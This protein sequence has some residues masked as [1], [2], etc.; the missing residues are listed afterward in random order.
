[1]AM[2]FSVFL[3]T[4]LHLQGR[5]IVVLAIACVVI[6]LAICYAVGWVYN[7][8][9]IFQKEATWTSTRNPEIMNIKYNVIRIRAILENRPT[10]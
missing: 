9:K 7:R 2:L 5:V 3:R 10:D 6:I 4:M 1:M 8:R